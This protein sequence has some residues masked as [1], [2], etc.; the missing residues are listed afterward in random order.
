[1]NVRELREII[2]AALDGDLGKSREISRAELEL[3]AEVLP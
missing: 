1:M 3:R 2:L